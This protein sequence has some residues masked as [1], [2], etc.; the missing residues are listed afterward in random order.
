MFDKMKSLIREKYKSAPSER[1]K[2]LKGFPEL[3]QKI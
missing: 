1:E 2:R 3:H